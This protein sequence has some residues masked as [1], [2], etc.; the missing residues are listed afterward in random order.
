MERRKRPKRCKSEDS[1]EQLAIDMLL[2]GVFCFVGLLLL[3]AFLGVVG[4]GPSDGPL[5]WM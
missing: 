5:P 3:A 4:V 1:V 2:A